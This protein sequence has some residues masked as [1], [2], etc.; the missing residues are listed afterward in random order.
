M[1]LV[2]DSK[3][4]HKVLYKDKKKTLAEVDTKDSHKKAELLVKEGKSDA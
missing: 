3:L 1:Q 4:V 2:P